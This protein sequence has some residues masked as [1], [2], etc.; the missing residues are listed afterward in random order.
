MFLDLSGITNLAHLCKQGEQLSSPKKRG[1]FQL[2]GQLSSHRLL[3]SQVLLESTIRRGHTAKCD[4]CPQLWLEAA[5]PNVLWGPRRLERTRP[6]PTGAPSGTHLQA[7]NHLLAM[8]RRAS[9]RAPRSFIPSPPRANHR[10]RGVAGGGGR[11]R[12]SPR[13]GRIGVGLPTS[14]MLHLAPTRKGPA[15]G[16]ADP[17][18]DPRDTDTVCTFSPRRGPARAPERGRAS[19][20]QPPTHPGAS[21]GTKGTTRSPCSGTA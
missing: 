18:A 2:F 11:G 3:P 8:C 15:C 10:P 19:Q 20:R 5:T 4:L 14:Q 1:K 16:R 17:K 7:Q 6:R 13:R 21:V 9:V 12:Q